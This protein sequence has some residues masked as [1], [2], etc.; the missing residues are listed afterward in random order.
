MG[1]D[2]PKKRE[3]KAALLVRL[4]NL[5]AVDGLESFASKCVRRSGMITFQRDGIRFSLSWGRGSG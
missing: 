3:S 2:Q 5:L 1:K 4:F